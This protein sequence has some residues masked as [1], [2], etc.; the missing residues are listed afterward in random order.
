MYDIIIIGAGVSGIFT[1]YTLIHENKN[2]RI[3]LIEKGKTLE[4][5]VCP[6]ESN[7]K[8]CLNC[9]ICNKFMGFGGMGRSEGKYNYTNDFGGYLGKLIGDK[10]AL[11][12]MDEVDKIL[13]KFGGDKA[14]FYSTENI[15]LKTKVEKHGFRLL[16]TKTRHLGTKLSL[17]I[18]N[19]MHEV[20][21]DK[22]DICFEKEIK[23][24][25]K[26]KEKFIIKCRDE[27]YYSKKVVLAT[28]LSGGEWFE[29]QCSHFGIVP[30]K[31]RL[32]LGFRLELKGDEL[33]NLLKE[34]FEIKLF[35]KDDKFESTTYCMNPN[36]KVIKKYQDG[37]IFADGQNYLEEKNSSQNLN[38]T[39]FI[40]SYFLSSKEA[41]AYVKTIMKNINENE[42][43]IIMQRLEDI[44]KQKTITYEDI[45]N[46]EII[47]S[48]KAKSVN[49]NEYVPQ[50]YI[51][52]TMLF[53][54]KLGDLLG[55]KI[56]PH[57]IFYG[58]DVKY[59]EPE[60]KVNKF[61]ESK[62]KGLYLAGD[63]SGIT[64]SLS[65]AAASGI[66]LGAYLSNN[67]A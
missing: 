60:M 30:Q 25:E 21:K 11:K 37:L 5:R 7:S 18:L 14:P 27:I 48:L 41:K 34:N 4:N 67:I 29:K 15:T 9:D 16:T 23:S 65:Q 43:K 50:K 24:I 13:C 10:K 39:L 66:Y 20:L 56:H 45:E 40:P 12:Y 28:G 35:Y 6:I 57:T 53:I 31:V 64:Y 2:L 46:S 55:K 54:E 38:F 44:K 62:V 8:N 61:F 52:S 17:E 42:E 47:P 51:D 63:C 3:K 1:A 36:G 59:Y 58:L 32:D 26:D 22:I 19:K 49:I 33:D